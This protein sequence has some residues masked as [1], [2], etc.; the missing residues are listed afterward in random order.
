MQ[1]S[2]SRAL[3]D[4]EDEITDHLLLS[5]IFAREIWSHLLC[6][7]GWERIAPGQGAVLSVWWMDA[8]KQVPRELQKGFDSALLL[9]SWVLWKVRNCRV[10]NDASST[11][12][13]VSRRFLG[14]GDEWVAAGFIAITALLAAAVV[15]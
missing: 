7:I 14:E 4:Q 13:Q 1:E 10:F 15:P 3:C 5:C 6:P 2:A 8:R 9:V 12:L 11:A